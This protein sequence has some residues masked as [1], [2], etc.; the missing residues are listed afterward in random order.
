[1]TTAE[2]LWPIVVCLFGILSAD[3]MLVATRLLGHLMELPA[4]DNDLLGRQ[5]VDVLIN[6]KE[7]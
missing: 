3:A 7:R 4:L 1:M 2:L 6:R 5:R